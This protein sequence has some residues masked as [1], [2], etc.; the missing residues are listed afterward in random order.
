MARRHYTALAVLVAIALAPVLL[1]AGSII[2]LPLAAFILPGKGLGGFGEAILGVASQGGGP[3]VVRGPGFLGSLEP[4]PAAD[5]ASYTTMIT[6]PPILWVPSLVAVASLPLIYALTRRRLHGSLIIPFS[7]AFLFASLSMSIALSV[8]IPP[9]ILEGARIPRVT[10]MEVSHDPITRSVVLSYQ[11]EGASIVGV[12]SCRVVVADAGF[13]CTGVVYPGGRVVVG[14]PLNAYEYLYNVSGGRVSSFIVEVNVS[15][16]R[17]W[18]SGSFKV[19]VL[20]RSL[21]VLAGDWR[22]TVENP[23]PIPFTLENVTIRYI[24]EG[25]APRLLRYE[26]LGDI[27]V[28]PGGSVYITAEPG[29]WAAYVSFKYKY[30]FAEGGVVEESVRL[31]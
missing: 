11:A 24:G 4:E 22:L 3:Y 5:K 16:E 8:L 17:G 12:N 15:L 19:N 14:I 9:S 27:I 26:A 31:G 20:W 2:G 21:R 29:S 18:A 1:G 28:P 23:N 7:V 13:N 10:L 25:A 6:L 30:K